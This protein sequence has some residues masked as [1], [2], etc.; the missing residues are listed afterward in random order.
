MI[1]SSLF[2]QTNI[3]QMNNDTNSI[4]R[5][6]IGFVP[7]KADNI[8]GWAIG[9]LMLDEKEKLKINGLYTNLSPFQL[10]WG[11]FMTIGLIWT[12]LGADEFHFETDNG[13]IYGEYIGIDSTKCNQLLNGISISIVDNAERT[14]I[15]GLEI[16]LVHQQT[17]VNNGISISG[18]CNSKTK[19]N[20][21]MIGLM[22]IAEKGNGL[23]IGLINNCGNLQ[24]FQI[25]LINR[26]G[27]RIIPFIN[28]R[29]KK[30]KDE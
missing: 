30:N 19:F 25:G 6:I 21:L 27:S 24:G 3:E 28:C 18:L 1:T 13:K 8:N 2:G 7:S 26:C 23:Q 22:N 14:K 10:Y 12:L 20:G 15:N 29:F 11:G 5:N 17:F 4:S 16:S 9:W